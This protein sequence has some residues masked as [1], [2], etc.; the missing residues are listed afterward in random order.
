MVQYVI[1]FDTMVG[2]IDPTVIYTLVTVSYTT[3]RQNISEILKS[4]VRAIS[5]SVSFTRL[6]YFVN[7]LEYLRY[8]IR[9]IVD[10]QSRARMTYIHQTSFSSRSHS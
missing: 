5:S 3:F 2:Y 4:M 8:I 6:V 1:K 7:L 9:S 10:L